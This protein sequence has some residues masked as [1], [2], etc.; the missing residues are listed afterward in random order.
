MKANEIREK[1]YEE[2]ENLLGQ[3]RKEL[4]NKR[5][6]LATNRLEDFSSIK[7][8]KREFARVK[9]IMTEKSQKLTK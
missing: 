6:Q 9:T 2:L 7:K 1:S 5:F 4:F 3:L 8:I